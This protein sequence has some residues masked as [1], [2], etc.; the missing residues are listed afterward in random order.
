MA[1]SINNR[2]LYSIINRAVA[3]WGCFDDIPAD[4]EMNI[5]CHKYDE[6]RQNNPQLN[7]FED[8][9]PSPAEVKIAK[10]LC[11]DIETY[12]KSIDIYAGTTEELSEDFYRRLYQGLDRY[13]EHITPNNELRYKTL[14]QT[15]QR[16]LPEFAE[17]VLFDQYNQT[18]DIIEY[19]KKKNH[20]E[21][22]TKAIDFFEQIITRD[23]SV[24]SDIIELKPTPEK[25]KFCKRCIDIV[26]CLPQERYSRSAKFTLK[27]NLYNLISKTAQQMG[28]SHT[29]K[30]AKNEEGRFQRAKKKAIQYAKDPNKRRPKR[31]ILG[32]EERNRRAMEEWIY[33]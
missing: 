33:K 26:D 5:F 11:S 19:L 14:K 32:I 2:E 7:V 10:Q 15:L 16:K 25:I 21:C 13:A 28:I 12:R 22:K 9:L 8:T 29:I 6:R 1:E 4:R 20:P 24:K 27:S 30:V 31:S 18:I 17:T 23:M 3:K